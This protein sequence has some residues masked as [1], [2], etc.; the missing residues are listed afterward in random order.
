MHDLIKVIYKS[1]KSWFRQSK[2]TGLVQ[3]NK[4]IGFRFLFLIHPFVQYRIAF[5]AYLSEGLPVLAAAEGFAVEDGEA[6]Y[7]KFIIPG[8]VLE[9]GP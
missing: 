4:L 9:F 8:A 3:I 7:L 5:E 6:V 1:S 2:Q